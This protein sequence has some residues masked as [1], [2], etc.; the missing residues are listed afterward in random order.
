MSMANPPARNFRFAVSRWYF[1]ANRLW[2]GMTGRD[3]VADMSSYVP[4][5]RRIWEEAAS[6][7]GADF[8]EIA[9]GFWEIRHAGRKTWIQ[10]FRVGIDDPVVMALAGNK[11]LCFD[12]MGEGGLPVPDYRRYRKGDME[13]AG[14]FLRESGHRLFVVK[15]AN[16]TSGGRGVTTHIATIAEFRRASALASLYGDDLL[17]ERMVPGESYRLLVLDG[18]MIHASRRSG[19]RIEGDGSTTIR[20]LL[21]RMD[22][23]ESAPSGIRRYRFSVPGRDIE[24]V[25]GN[26]GLTLDDVPEKGRTVL[27]SGRGISVDRNAEVTTTYDEDVTNRIG[28]DMK[29]QAEQAACIIGSR[30]AGV[31]IITTDPSV[32]L[33]QSGGMINEVN[34]TPGLHNHYRLARSHDENVPPA[35]PVLKYL[36]GIP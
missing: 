4:V 22:G 36:L 3:P 31:D 34:T 21:E 25:L 8:R 1:R 5:Y 33:R 15:P 19:L 30:F 20:T 16:G 27:V 12:L 10:N 32:P 28:P 14:R 11:P 26:Q 24:D 2:T 29:R 7:L 23:T 17:I 6:R 13:T 9:D 35:I 18:T